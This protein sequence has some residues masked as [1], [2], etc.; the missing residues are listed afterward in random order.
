MQGNAE[1]AMVGIALDRV[2][3]RHL[4]RDEQRQQGQTQQR[5]KTESSVL[6]A[7]TAEK[8]WRQTCQMRTLQFLGYTVL[9]AAGAARVPECA[10]FTFI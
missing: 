10:V 5:R 1:R 4:D 2:N 3:V 8:L 9:D 7:A 6:T